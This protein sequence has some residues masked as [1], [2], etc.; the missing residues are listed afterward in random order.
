MEQ[1]AMLRC[2]IDLQSK[3][4]SFYPNRLFQINFILLSISEIL[5]DEHEKSFNAAIL[6]SIGFWT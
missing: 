5:G 2:Q 1:H 3:L 6:T 4:R